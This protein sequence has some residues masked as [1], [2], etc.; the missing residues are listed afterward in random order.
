MDDREAERTPVCER[1]GD[2][3]PDAQMEGDGDVLGPPDFVTLPQVVTLAH[4]LSVGE[5]LMVIV[6]EL[7]R[8]DEDS[9][10]VVVREEGEGESECEMLMVS[11]AFVAEGAVETDTLRLGLLVMEGDVVTLTAPEAE[12]ERLG[13]RLLVPLNDAVA[14]EDGANESVPDI[15]ALGELLACALRLGERLEEMEP[16]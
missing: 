12:G 3:L 4:W 16:V 11:G 15:D 14:E 10:E 7:V 2:T 13:E 6:I 8:D 9:R 1:V 5:M